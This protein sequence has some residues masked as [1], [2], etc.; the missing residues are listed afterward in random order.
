MR[1]KLTKDLLLSNSTHTSVRDLLRRV[2]VTY[3]VIYM[4]RKL[5]FFDFSMQLCCQKPFIL[6]YLYAMYHLENLYMTY[7]STNLYVTNRC[8]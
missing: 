8:A 3:H 6:S 1:M 7:H 5:N 4:S 2:H